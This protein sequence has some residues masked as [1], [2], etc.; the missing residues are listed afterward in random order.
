[1]CRKN[2]VFGWCACALGAGILI[3]SAMESG[4]LAFVLGLGLVLV[5]LACFRQK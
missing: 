2:Q 4:L 5:G 1:M 3:G